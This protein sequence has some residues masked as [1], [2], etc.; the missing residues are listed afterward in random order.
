MHID[1]PTDVDCTPGK[2]S[3][4]LHIRDI[5]IIV[6]NN[7]I[8]IM[9]VI[10]NTVEFCEVDIADALFPRKTGFGWIPSRI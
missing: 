4:L 7:I 3:L 6:I 10:K 5:I 9:L 1:R 8:V 2:K